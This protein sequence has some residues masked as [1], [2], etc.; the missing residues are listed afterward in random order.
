MKYIKAEEGP[1]NSV[2]Y[3]DEKGDKLIRY[4]KRYDDEPVQERSTRSWRNNNPGNHAWDTFAR[5]NGAIG[6]AG[7]V[8]GTK[9]KF[10]VYP[11]YITGRKAQAKLLRGKRYIDLTLNEF[12]RKYTGV[13][14]GQPDSK[15]VIDYRKAIRFFTK[16]EMDRTIR[17]LTDEEYEKLLDAMKTQE[18][19]RAGKEEYIE[20]KNILG[21][22]YNKKKVIVEFLVGSPEKSTWIPK[23]ETI[24]L[25]EKG[26]LHAVVVHAKLS[27]YLRPEYHKPSFKQLA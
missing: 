4:W 20:V 16:F 9:Y 25:T 7:T 19:W 22:R 14:P 27:T 3:Y 24:T 2:I 11:D 10:T 6:F 15:E 12:L 8:L 21:V 17:S 13:K 26:C 1:N 5:E 23:A 18:G